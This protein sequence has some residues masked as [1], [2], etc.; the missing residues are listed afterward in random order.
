MQSA[1]AMGRRHGPVLAAFVLVT[2]ACTWPLA[3]HLTDAVPRDLGDPLL[4]IW[5]LWWNAHTLPFTAAWWNG[6]VFVPAAGSLAFSDHRVG[7]GLF[8]SPLI[9]AGASP[10]MAYNVTLLL[11]F[12]LSALAA[13]ALALA[14]TGRRLPAFAAGLA[15]GFH[16]FR[17]AHLEHLELLSAFW[18]PVVF[19]CLH[20]WRDQRAVWAPPGLAMS[21]TMLAVTSGYYFVFG[22]VLVAGWVLWFARGMPIADIGK[23]AAALV[24]PFLVIAPILL[25]YRAVHEALG[26]T[27]SI[28]DIELF[29]ADVVDFLVAPEA[30]ALWPSVS[31]GTHPE[32]ALFPGLTALGLTVW[33]VVRHRSRTPV[34]AGPTRL[35]LVAAVVGVVAFAVALASLGGLDAVSFGPLRLSFRQAYKPLSIATAAFA[36]WALTSAWVRRAWTDR[37]ILAF[38]A[39]GIVAL[40]LCALGPTARVAGERVLFKAPYAWLMLLPGVGGA[41][42]VPARFAMIAAFALSVTAALALA[43]WPPATSWRR[44]AAWIVVVAGVLADGWVAPLALHAPPRNL[45]VPESVAPDE[46]IIELPIGTYEDAAAMYRAISHRHPL[47][48]GL[49]GYEPAHYIVLREALRDGDVAALVPLAARRPLVAFVAATG[50]GQA[51]AESMAAVPGAVRIATT[52]THHVFRLSVPVSGTVQEPLHV[53]PIRDASAIP[54]EDVALMLDDNP[55]TVWRTPPQHGGE[56][57][58]F[59]LGA[60]AVVA[61]ITLTLGAQVAAYPRRLIVDVSDDGVE[62]RPAWQGQPAALVVAAALVTPHHVAFTVSFAPQSARFVRLTQVARADTAWEVASVSLLGRR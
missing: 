12:V 15:F 4:S 47:V 58:R 51:I 46:P 55:A 9:W 8:A 39:L 3:W 25:T 56:Q 7:L 34:S 28:T 18:L 22:G 49:S 21:L 61:G 11:T 13:Y 60:P 10:L 14:L 38:Y 16:P 23:L 27:R 35:R 53:L 57:L 54:P 52:P 43:R 26:F 44:R 20:R 24:V 30:L 45:D 32:R 31:P 17:A 48:N 62:W 50:A 59:D 36:L 37:S 2:V 6:P 40:W 5:T 29:S 19:L 42:R 33:A 1:I 41:F